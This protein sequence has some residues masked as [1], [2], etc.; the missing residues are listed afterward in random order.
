MAHEFRQSV[1]AAILAL[2]LGAVVADE[3]E[4]EEY[5]LEDEVEYEEEPVSFAANDMDGYE[6]CGRGCGGAQSARKRGA[7]RSPTTS[8]VTETPSSARGTATNVPV[9]YS[10]LPRAETNASMSAMGTMAAR[11]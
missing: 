4:V 3:E 1:L 5:F 9:R 7:N 10:S 6:Y 11:A 8:P 2:C